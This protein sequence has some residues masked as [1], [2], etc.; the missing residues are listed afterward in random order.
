MLAIN[1]SDNPY[2]EQQIVVSGLV[3]TLVMRFNIIDSSWY[4][5]IKNSSST[6]DIKV[7]IKVMPNQNLTG[8]YILPSLEGGNI[9]CFRKV[10]TDSEIGRDNLGIDKEY[11][12]YW[13]TDE[14]TEE[15]GLDGVLQL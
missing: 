4:L 5:D 10:D 3:L 13:I 11:C 2:S 8:R 1:T 15:A 6:V 14:E 12:L 9:W 7:G